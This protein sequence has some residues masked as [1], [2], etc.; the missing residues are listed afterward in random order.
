MI[1]RNTVRGMDLAERT[2][3]LFAIF[4]SQEFDGLAALLAAD[5]KMKQ[6]GN[7]E[8]DVEGL[9]A[10]VQG[11]KNDGVAVKYS[12]VRRSVGDDFVEQHVVTLT[13]PDGKSASTDV[14]VVLRFDDVGLITRLDEY[15]DSA[16]FA[17]LV[18]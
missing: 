12:D 9:M 16:V 4:E 1:G 7:P 5:A 17:T 15:A 10:F 13:R 14:C 2:A 18:D 6:N 3:Q 8:H 11:L